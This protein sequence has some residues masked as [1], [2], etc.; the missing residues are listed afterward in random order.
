MS[1]MRVYK[2]PKAQSD[3]EDWAKNIY[4][5]IDAGSDRVSNFALEVLLVSRRCPSCLARLAQEGK[6]PPADQ[7]L[8]E[9]A[10]CCATA[11]GF[12]RPGMPLKEIVF[13]FLLKE[14]KVSLEALHYALTEEWAIPTN[15]MN[16]SRAALKRL[17][18]SDSWY[19]FTGTAEQG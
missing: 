9:I 18:D 6:I 17:L 3:G 5:T 1:A 15:P 8:E 13:R 2:G 10:R 12:I 16:I 11:D 19:G 14:G 7:Q 4:Y